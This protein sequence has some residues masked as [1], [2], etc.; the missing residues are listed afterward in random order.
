MRRLHLQGEPQPAGRLVPLAGAPG[1]DAALE[2]RGGRGGGCAG[3]LDEGRQAGIGH[4]EAPGAGG[5]QAFGG[6]APV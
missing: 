6:R 5:F 4:G 2:R 1:R 3:W